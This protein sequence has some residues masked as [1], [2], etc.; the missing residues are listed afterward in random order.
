MNTSFSSENFVLRTWR[1]EVGSKELESLSDFLPILSG[2]KN[3]NSPTLIPIPGIVEG[4]GVRQAPEGPPANPIMDC[5]LDGKG[6]HD[7]NPLELVK[8]NLRSRSKGTL[9]FTRK[10]TGE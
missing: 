10:A 8:Y 7:S 9:D 4:L 3:P 1:N 5:T 6:T 2:I